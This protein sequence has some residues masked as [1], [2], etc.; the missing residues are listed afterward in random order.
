MTLTAILN[1]WHES[2]SFNLFEMSVKTRKQMRKASQLVSI[3]L[4]Q[5]SQIYLR[6][7]PTVKLSVSVDIWQISR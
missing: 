4:N 5:Y 7:C 3:V 2:L 1:V 6:Y